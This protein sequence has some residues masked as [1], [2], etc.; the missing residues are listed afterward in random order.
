MISRLKNLASS[1]RDSSSLAAY[2]KRFRIHSRF[3]CLDTNLLRQISVR[4][5]PQDPQSLHQR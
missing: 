1:G 5:E 2:A 3:Q 4:Q